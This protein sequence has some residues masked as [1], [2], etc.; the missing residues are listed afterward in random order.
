MAKRQFV[1]ES[2]LQEIA[3]NVNI[4]DEEHEDYSSDNSIN[5]PN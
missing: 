5:D 4:S 3:E 1:S 2:E